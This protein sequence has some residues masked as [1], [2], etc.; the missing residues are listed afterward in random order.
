[1]IH[2]GCCHGGCIEN[3]NENQDKISN[4]FNPCAK[5]D[6]FDWLRDLPQNYKYFDAVE[7][8]FKNTRKAF[9]RNNNQLR[10]KRGDIVAIEASPGHDIGIVC[11]TGEIVTYQMMKYGLDP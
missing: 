5:L 8:R 10:L 11:L 4:Y 1:M 6:D 7:I 3:L 9:F 2:R